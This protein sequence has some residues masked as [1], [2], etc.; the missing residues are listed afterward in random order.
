MPE[1]RINTSN[2]VTFTVYEGCFCCLGRDECDMEEIRHS[3]DC[4]Y[5]AAGNGKPE[6]DD[7]WGEKDSTADSLDLR[8][9]SLHTYYH[10]TEVKKI[11]DYL[12]N[13]SVWAD[14][15][16]D[17]DA[18]YVI[19]EGYVSLDP[20][21]SAEY[22]VNAASMVRRAYD[23]ADQFNEYLE[24][25]ASEGVALATCFLHRGCAAYYVGDGIDDESVINFHDWSKDT[26]KA[27]VNGTLRPFSCEEGTW[28]EYR[29]YPQNVLNQWDDGSSEDERWWSK[30]YTNSR[31]MIVA[32]AGIL[33]NSSWEIITDVTSAEESL[34]IVDLDAFPAKV[35][36]YVGNPS[37]EK[38]TGRFGGYFKTVECG[39]R[40]PQVSINFL[41]EFANE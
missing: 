8:L 25:G 24:Q 35:M 15:F 23:I 27:F 12:F 10:G 40:D 20:N 22:M 17:D 11:F 37:I 13:R 16:M 14:A 41:M 5:S 18:E 26:L 34:N 31:Q 3:Y 19:T 28:N 6:G 30:E 9:T 38:V 2:G 21:V 33:R 29:G 1:V 36:G 4:A 32:S 39:S 7:K